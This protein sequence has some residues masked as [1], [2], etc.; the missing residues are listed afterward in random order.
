MTKRAL[1]PEDW[2][3]AGLDALAQGGPA[4]LRAEAIARDIGA[5]KGSFYWHFRDLPA[6]KAAIL[7]CWQRHCTDEI[8]A[9]A[10]THPDPPSR[11]AALIALAT[12]LPDPADPAPDHAA[13]QAIRGWSRHDPLA[14]E[15]VARVDQQRLAYLQDQLAGMG[16]DAG[17]NARL[18]YAAHLGLELLAPEDSDSRAADLRQLLALLTR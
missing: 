13:E 6:Y 3:K 9:L 11:L 7:A 1:S 16:G 4:A 8:I 12:A 15:A 17:R 5:T 10:E 14:A 18:I 2:I